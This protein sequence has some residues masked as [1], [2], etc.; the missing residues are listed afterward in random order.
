MAFSS[1][2]M[3]IATFLSRILGLI[4]E[5]A[6]AAVF[7]AGSITDAFTV[8]YRVPNMLRDL[9]AEGSFSSA[10]VPLF[11]EER[12]KDPYKARVLLWSVFV[13][14]GLPDRYYLDSHH[15]QRK[16]HCSFYDKR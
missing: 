3:A 6:M 5:Q 9:L 11:I 13:L 14:V 15:Y 1:A 16:T 12:L 10:F 2:K 7:G 8:A 4:R